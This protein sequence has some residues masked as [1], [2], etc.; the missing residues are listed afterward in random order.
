MGIIV[1]YLLLNNPL[2]VFLKKLS[3]DIILKKTS[4]G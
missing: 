2:P 4:I 1:Q 3:D